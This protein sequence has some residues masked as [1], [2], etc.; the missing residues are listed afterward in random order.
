MLA[1]FTAVYASIELRVLFAKGTELR[2]TM[3]SLH[4]MLGL[5]IFFLVW[6][7]LLVR[8]QFPAPRIEPAPPQ[9]QQTTARLV[10]GLLY[11]LMIGKNKDWQPRSRRFMNWW[12]W[13]LTSWSVRMR[14]RRCFTT[15]SNA[16]AP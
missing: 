2:E 15:A 7:P 3:K 11:A 1:L 16:T 8:A 6:L 9:W 13:R 14:L 10:H 12:A 5:L 4:F